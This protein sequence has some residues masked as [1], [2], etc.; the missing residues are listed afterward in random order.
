MGGGPRNALPANRHNA[1]PSVPLAGVHCSHCALRANCRGVRPCSSAKPANRGCACSQLQPQPQTPFHHVSAAATRRGR[2]SRFGPPRTQSTHHDRQRSHGPDAARP[3]ARARPPRPTRRPTA[4]QPTANARQ[5][6]V[7]RN[8][9]RT[10]LPAQAHSAARTRLRIARLAESSKAR[11]RPRSEG[12]N[13]IGSSHGTGQA[14]VSGSADT[15]RSLLPLPRERARIA[16]APP[17][18]NILRVAG[19]S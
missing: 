8:A 16:E 4:R 9:P 11:A 14:R 3:P 18:P 10:R 2:Q 6:H 12:I 13:G 17:L 7:A 5:H 1:P 19:Q 15:M